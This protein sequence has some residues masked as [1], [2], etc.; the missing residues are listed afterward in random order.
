MRVYNVWARGKINTLL[1]SPGADSPDTNEW[2]TKGIKDG[3]VTLTPKQYSVKFVK[4]VSDDI[5]DNLAQYLI[6]QG[7]A[8]K[9]PQDEVSG[10]HNRL[11]LASSFE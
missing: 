11:I 1:V 8:Y 7:L 9:R 6:D 4:G 3:T 5:P 2:M 10:V